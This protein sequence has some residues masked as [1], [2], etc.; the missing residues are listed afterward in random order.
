MDND[1]LQSLTGNAPLFDKLDAYSDYQINYL[2]NKIYI[3]SLKDN[4]NPNITNN[5]FLNLTMSE[6]YDNIINVIPNLYKDYSKNYL[7]NSIDL[8]QNSDYVPEQLIVKHTLIDLL[9]TKNIIYLGI[10]IIFTSFFLYII[11]L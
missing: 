8:K 11:N 5:E 10:I 7:K 2:K 6:I 4:S 1:I 9:S 3:Q